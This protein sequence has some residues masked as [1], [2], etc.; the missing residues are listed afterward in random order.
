MLQKTWK[1][2]ADNPT[3][4]LV[5]WVF[6]SSYLSRPT[7]NFPIPFTFR[8]M[9]VFVLAIPVLYGTYLAFAKPKP[10]TTTAVWWKHPLFLLTTLG[11]LIA[12]ISSIMGVN[13][14]QS[15][16][17]SVSRGDG[18]IFWSSLYVFLVFLLLSIRSESGWRQLLLALGWIAWIMAFYGLLQKLIPGLVYVA[19]DGYISSLLGNRV[20]TASFMV[21]G[22]PL[23]MYQAILHPAIWKKLFWG[24]GALLS[25]LIIIW[26]QSTGGIV[27]LIATLFIFT[28]LYLG[29]RYRWTAK[30]LWLITLGAIL[31]AT[32]IVFL[33]LLNGQSLV[34]YYLNHPTTISRFGFY[35]SAWESLL[36]RP[37]GYGWENTQIALQEHYQLS[38]SVVGFNEATSD[39]IHNTFLQQAVNGGWLSLITS[40]IAVLTGA[41]LAFKHYLNSNLSSQS[42]IEISAVIASLLG[43]LVALQFSFNV[44]VTAIYAI[45]LVAY[46]IYHT[47]KATAV[48]SKYIYNWLPF[49]M[50]LVYLFIAVRYM[51]P[52]IGPAI[53]SDKALNYS[54]HGFTQEAYETIDQIQDRY[55]RTPY[56]YELI[57]R[58]SQI[59]EA[60]ALTLIDSDSEKYQEVIHNSLG[61]L[62]QIGDV[63]NR[64]YILLDRPVLYAHLSTIDADTYLPLMRSSFEEIKAWNPDNPYL[65]L[66]WVRMLMSAERFDEAKSVIDNLITS[67]EPP[68][69]TYLWQAALR[70]FD[71]DSTEAVIE[72]IEA[73]SHR[74]D[75]AIIA[76]KDMPYQIIHEFNKRLAEIER[77][78]LVVLL[79]EQLVRTSRGEIAEEWINLAVAYANI[80]QLDKAVTATRKSVE[81]NPELKSAAIQFLA[82][83]G[84]TL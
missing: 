23:L 12:W 25:I 43:Y 46:L 75:L 26:T 54:N 71:G 82:Q 3:A 59:S 50:L 79:Q 76:S 2:I 35:R 10:N 44:V 48:H 16:W 1:T 77:W 47:T 80:N 5:F 21:L 72:S 14:Y 52:T 32:V 51:I 69:G 17:G 66:F 27:A 41:Y 31:L 36:A 40:L 20:Y 30:T 78:D 33:P 81:I 24:F 67:P 13:L 83:Y 37:F 11:L 29:I 61:V 56:Y 19:E 38:S 49:L 18:L 4:T 22:L 57:R 15:I 9:L 8:R 6:S 68:R 60:Y 74:N 28:L 42:R 34:E 84:R 73:A 45:M 39:R 7:P 53:L 62:N 70:Q 64:D 58:H 65:D 55:H 63:F